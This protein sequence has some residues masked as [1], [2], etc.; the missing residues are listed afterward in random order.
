M[1]KIKLFILLFVLQINL[2]AQSYFPLPDSNAVWTISSLAQGSIKGIYKF[3]V[4]GDTS[5]NNISYNKVYYNND[6]NFN[7]TNSFLFGLIRESNK[8]VYKYIGNNSEAI[9]YDFNL[10]IGDSA[11]SISTN[12][13]T[14]S[15]KVTDIDSVLINGQFRKRWIF[16][17]EY[18]IEGIGSSFG[19][20]DPLV[21]SFDFCRSLICLSENAIVTYQNANPDCTTP[22]PYDCDGILNPISVSEHVFKNSKSIIFPNPFSNSAIIKTS[23]ELNDAALKIYDLLG[24]EVLTNSHLN[25]QEI[26]I[27]KENLTNGNY[28]YKLTQN[29]EL[30]SKGKF[31]IE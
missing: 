10:I 5:I 11:K 29:G 2:N 27:N 28:Y 22:A 25:G 30:I 26:K 19:L 15:K 8:K 20:L 16:P 12:G 9:L 1:K 24:Q 23:I 13:F 17:E 21:Q 7:L 14:F 18:W 4:Y 3:G 31:I 6:Y